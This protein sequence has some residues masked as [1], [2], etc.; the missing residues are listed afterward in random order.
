MTERIGKEEFARMISG[1][2]A[3][4]RSQ[5][6]LLSQLD[7]AAGDGDHG[8]T[9]LRTMEQMEKAAAGEEHVELRA[10]FKEAGWKIMGVDGGASSALIGTFFL[11]MADTP[12]AGAPCER[13]ASRP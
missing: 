13:R 7:S 11:G 4:I 9:M 6:V 3:L 8:V 10:M 5:H 1:A 2:A 12:A